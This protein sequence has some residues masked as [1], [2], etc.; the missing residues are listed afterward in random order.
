M[1]GIT[2]ERWR[3]DADEALDV[4][5]ALGERVVLVATSMG[6][7]LALDLAVRLPNTS[8]RSW[9]GRLVSGCTTPTSCAP[10]C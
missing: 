7:S 2:P 3:T 5:L 9:P 8:P 1:A 10:P 4:G 6:G